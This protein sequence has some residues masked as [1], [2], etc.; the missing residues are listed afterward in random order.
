VV[1]VDR[2]S[3][4]PSFLSSIGFADSSAAVRSAIQHLIVNANRPGIGSSD[5]QMAS[6][7]LDICI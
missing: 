2:D 6:V 4:S 7:K 3:N 5:G 1:S